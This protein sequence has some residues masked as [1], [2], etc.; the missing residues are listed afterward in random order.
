MNQPRQ[1]ILTRAVEEVKDGMCV[2][3]GI[4]MRR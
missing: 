3:L 2:N 4:G 1:R